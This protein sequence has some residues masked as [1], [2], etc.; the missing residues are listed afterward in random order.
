MAGPDRRPDRPAGGQHPGRHAATCCAAPTSTTASFQ[1]F[2]ADTGVFG[3]AA[4]HAE[5][6]AASLG[7]RRRRGL[8]HRPVPAD[9]L[10][11]LGEGL[12]EQADRRLEGQ[13]LR[14]LRL[15]R[16]RPTSSSPVS[17]VDQ[18]DRDGPADRVRLAWSTCRSLDPR[19][20]EVQHLVHDAASRSTAPRSPSW[21][22]TRPR[23]PTRSRPR[24]FHG[25][26]V[27]LNKGFIGVGS[28]NA[29]G[30]FDNI[31]VQVLPPHGEPGPDRDL[32]D[33]RRN[34]ER[35]RRPA[36]GP[37]PAASCT[38]PRPRSSTAAS[39]WVDLGGQLSANAFLELTG[40]ISLDA[41]GF[42]GIAFDAYGIDDYKF[43]ALDIAGQRIVLGHVEPRHPGGRRLRGPLVGG[44]HDLHRA[45][46]HQ[47]RLGQRR[48]E[49]LVRQVDGLQQRPRRRL[50]RPLRTHRNRARRRTAPPHGRLQRA[51]VD[52]HDHVIDHLVVELDHVRARQPCRRARRSSPRHDDDDIHCGYARPPT[53][54]RRPTGSAASSP[55]TRLRPATARSR[56]PTRRRP[57]RTPVR[58]RSPSEGTTE[59]EPAL[60]VSPTPGRK[61]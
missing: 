7:Q 31:A 27:A 42:G 45:G 47:G 36:P 25:E 39:A 34:R 15:L 43:A 4:G 57:A 17:T 18:Q 20:R 16:S 1:A 23:S 40:K 22:T 19:R 3:G 46:D 14:H 58:I 48:G 32:R 54:R 9:L 8:Q 44:R 35:R 56:P 29:R 53:P 21:S 2:A 26:L 55:P 30:Q 24:L 51:D 37:C 28:D 6:R 13:R 52:R 11:G 41:G 61:K 33:H 38:A 5:G 60:P 50:L 12:H 49:R 10:R 59:P